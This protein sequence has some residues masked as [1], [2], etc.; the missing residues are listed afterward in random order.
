MKIAIATNFIYPEGLGG[1]ELYCYQLAKALKALGHEVFWFVPNFD[2]PDT[3]LSDNDAGIHI[4]RFAA[5]EQG[6]LPHAA[7]V[8]HSFIAELNNRKIDVVHFNEFGGFEGMSTSLLRETSRAGIR[9]IVTMHLVHYIC[10]AGTLRRGGFQSCDG[11]VIPN[12]CA[13]CM[14]FS[15]P[16]TPVKNAFRLPLLFYKAANISDELKLSFSRFPVFKRV[17]KTIH[18]RLDFISALNHHADEIVSLTHNFRDLLIR[19]GIRGEKITCIGQ[20]SPEDNTVAD[21]R[22]KEIRRNYVFIS[23]VHKEKG[24]GLLLKAAKQMSTSAPGVNIDI[25][26]PLPANDGYTKRFIKV[27]AGMENIHYKGVLKPGDVGPVLRNYKAVL[28]PSYVAEMAPLTIMEA[29]SEKTAVIASD[30]PGS[31]ELV[32]KHQ[33]GLVFKYGSSLDL[34]EKILSIERGMHEFRFL[35]PENKSFMDIAE[36]YETLY[37]SARAVTN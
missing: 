29:I 31:A 27:I 4:V 9:T 10:M 13:G 11:I 35:M 23:R 16:L 26:G 25:Y 33:A 12:R 34:V 30:V 2:K 8:A 14:M 17:Y 20:G 7:F 21:R 1:T 28:L 15:D 5:V 24:I 32:R 18:G 6:K 3:V 37:K 19:N 22:D 36:K